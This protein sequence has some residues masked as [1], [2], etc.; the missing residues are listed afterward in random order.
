MS[1]PDSFIDEVTEEVRRDR[2]FVLMRRYGWIAI[3]IVV[4]IV[5]GAAW[6]EWQK[7][8][9]QTDARAFGDELLTALD[10]NAPEARVKALEA[11]APGDTGDQA[12]IKDLMIASDADGDKAAALAALDKIAADP[13][14]SEDYRDLAI[15][16]RVNLAG[17]ELSI[18]DRR[19]ALDPLTTA[20]RPFRPLALEQMAYLS[21]E[22]G[23]TADAI[24][25]L[26][27][28]TIEQDAPQGLRQRAGQ[29][30]VALGGTVVE[31]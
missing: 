13:T 26:R 1:N 16:R 11:V 23:D 2:L 22:A 27:A 24:T 15:L 18:A 3:L 4:L 9:H 30:I 7:S 21:V 29:M 19:A 6:I 14:V 10:Q 28:L 17:A 31:G 20:G 5:G 25:R 8:R 12:A